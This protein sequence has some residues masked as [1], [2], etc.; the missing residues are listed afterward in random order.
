MH[1]LLFCTCLHSCFCSDIADAVLVAY[2]ETI[3]GCSVALLNKDS[4]A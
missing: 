2:G 1:V 4:S 3:V